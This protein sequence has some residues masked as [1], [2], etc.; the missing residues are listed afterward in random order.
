MRIAQARFLSDTNTQSDVVAKV[1]LPYDSVRSD[2]LL[3]EQTVFD[4]TVGQCLVSNE[5]SAS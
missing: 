1:C 3:W 4:V 5:N 2:Q